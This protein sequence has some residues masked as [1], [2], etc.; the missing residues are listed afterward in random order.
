[1]S[2]HQLVRDFF[3][4]I[5]S[6]DLPDNLVTDDMAAWT[7]TSGDTSKARFAGGVKLL[8]AIFNGSLV[9]TMDSITAEDDRAVAECQS[10]G[11][12]VDGQEFHNHH[13]FLFE[14]RDGRIS[15]VREYM[16]PMIVAEKIV[17]LMTQ[18][19]AKAAD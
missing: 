11:K 12:L 13:V 5:A 4:A 3:V 18:F 9:Y 1:M 19:N 7:L 8:A 10:S 15:S 17:P 14:I 6:G 16:N 2:N